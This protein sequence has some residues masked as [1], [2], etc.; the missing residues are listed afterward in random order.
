M[1]SG[2]PC[3][4]FPFLARH[5]F[6][7][8][9]ALC[10][11][12]AYPTLTSKVTIP[13]RPPILASPSTTRCHRFEVDNSHST[14]VLARLWL[15]FLAPHVICQHSTPATPTTCLP[16]LATPVQIPPQ[17]GNSTIASIV[18]AAK[19]A[20]RRIS[21]RSG[22]SQAKPGR[23]LGLIGLCPRLP[24]DGASK[25]RRRRRPEP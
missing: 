22:Q 3:S 17:P 24:C 11:T 5:A 25:G 1:L 15:W 2:S 18:K 19:A 21:E 13:S 20:N 4:N 10:K 8:S 14:L 16:R 12:P 7:G 6:S 9:L 23:Q